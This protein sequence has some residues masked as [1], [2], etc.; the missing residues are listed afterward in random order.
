MSEY[1]ISRNGLS[2]I[3]VFEGFRGYQYKDATG[4][5]TI[6]YGTTLGAGVVKPL[7]KTCTHEE[8]EQWLGEYVNRDIIPA[9]EVAT[10]TGGRKFNQNEVDACCSLGYNLG[11]GIFGAEHTIGQH[12]RDHRFTHHR[13]GEDF[14]LYE[15]ADGHTLAGLVTRR[16]AERTL[17]DR[18]VR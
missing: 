8:A 4:V 9:I 7:P 3:E 6:G 1:H 17:F 13:I 5:P 2:L 14:L 11:A 10:K 15:S 18:P 16:E 12:I